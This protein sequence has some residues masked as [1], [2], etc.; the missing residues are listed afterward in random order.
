MGC[1]IGQY[2]EWDFQGQLRWELLTFAYHR[3][4]QTMVADLNRLY[5]AEPAMHEV[6]YN[7]QGFEWV[8]FRDVENSVM[9]AI[10]D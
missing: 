3:K 9:Q 2:E 6:D 10:V 4:L 7:W 8:D 1:E 5:A